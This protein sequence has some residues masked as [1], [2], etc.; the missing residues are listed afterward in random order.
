M[1][2]K[3]KHVYSTRKRAENWAE[4]LDPTR[5]PQDP[6]EGIAKAMR[7]SLWLNFLG[8]KG[9]GVEEARQMVRLIVV[10]VPELCDE[11]LRL[12]EENDRLRGRR[13][14]EC[15]AEHPTNTSVIPCQLD[16]GHGP[17]FSTSGCAGG[18]ITW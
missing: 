11:V 13:S 15:G 16:K 4:K 10:D 5:F 1:V 14:A 6:I 3:I 9:R 17:H 18:E 12:R 8:S 7:S 2:M